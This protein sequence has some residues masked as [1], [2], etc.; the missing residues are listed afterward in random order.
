MFFQSLA[1]NLIIRHIE[2][3]NMSQDKQKILQVST[4]LLAIGLLTSLFY[5]NQSNQALTGQ[6]QTLL[7]A[8]SEASSLSAEIERLGSE[9]ETAD[10][11]IVELNAALNE[12]RNVEAEPE[13]ESFI[14]NID[15]EG[16]PRNI[17]L[18]IGDGMGI[19][20]ITAA[21]L[22]NGDRDLAMTSLPYL[23]LVETRSSGYYVTDSAAAATAIATGNKTKNGFISMSPNGARLTTVL[24]SAKSLGKS[25]GIVTTTIITHGTPAAFL[26]HVTNRGDYDAIAEQTLMS[27]TDVLLGGGSSSFSSQEA[28]EQGYTIINSRDEL[29]QF[30]NGKVLGLFTSD[31]MNYNS[32]RDPSSEPSLVEMTENSMRLL[33][34]DP[35]GFFLVVEG[36]LIDQA[37]HDND[38][39]DTLEEVI[40]FDK[41]VYAALR[42]AAN[43]NDTLVIVT[44]DHETGGFAITGGTPPNNPNYGWIGTSHTG[45][46]V[47]VYGYGP[48]AELVLT[49]KDN[50][51]LGILLK[52][53][54]E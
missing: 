29:L 41:A 37:A 48:S 19:A 52:K 44:A 13:A 33:T 25:T 16:V 53:L 26:A 10:T 39:Q 30:E 54:L 5:L 18:L 21:K 23:A 50:T 49:L 4:I 47:P 45:V 24:E 14:L 27:D 8:T 20:Q 15:M 7:A 11:T 51:D 9:L 36:G 40:E 34:D 28:A 2:V 1:P 31:H 32:S 22:I 6:Q 12:S 43:R 38:P 35:E 3:M 17:I 46:M 42:F